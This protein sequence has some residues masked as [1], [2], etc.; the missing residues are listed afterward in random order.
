MEKQLLE[1]RASKVAFMGVGA[2]PTYHRMTGF[3][4]FTP[5]KNPKEFTRQ[6]LDETFERTDVVSYAPAITFSFDSHSNNEVHKD[7]R[8]IF[9]NE[10]IGTDAERTII[11]VDMSD[12]TAIKRAYNIIPDNEASTP[13]SYTYAGSF[14]ANG[15]IEKVNVTSS[16]N[17]LTITEVEPE[18]VG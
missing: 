9:D 4:E 3:T 11:I 6:Y 14:R 8:S 10:C 17:F 2:T 15:A 13:D 1:Q 7:I 12:K 16:D 18:V 5:S